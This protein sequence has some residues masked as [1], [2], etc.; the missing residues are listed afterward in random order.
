MLNFN[1]TK[2]LS[3]LMNPDKIL[4]VAMIEVACTGG[5][6]YN[7]Y[8]RGGKVEG[9]ERLREETTGAVFWLFGVKV[10]NK[11][12]DFIGNKIGIKNLD[13]DLGKDELR[14]P[15]LN[16][17]KDGANKTIAFKFAKVAGSA[18]IATFFLGFVLPKI[19]QKITEISRNKEQNS[20]GRHSGDNLELKNNA[21]KTEISNNQS[22]A[23]PFAAGLTYPS[24]D[25]FINSAKQRNI[26]FKGASPVV[27]FLS[28]AAYNLENKTA[29][30]LMS[31]DVGMIA[32][33]VA[34]SRNKIEGFEFL[35]RD[36]TSIYFYL[37]ATP[38][39]VSLLNKMTGNTPIH[40]DSLEVFKNHL[41]NSMGDKKYTLEEF[42]RNTKET[43]A[44]LSDILTKIKFEKDVTSL[45]KFN[46][47]TSGL[48]KEK[49][50]KMSQLQPKMLGESILSKQ[51]VVDIL[52]DGWNTDPEFIK[53]ALD[54]GTYGAASNPKK[55]VT[56]KTVEGIRDSI[57]NFT[58]NLVKYASDKGVKEIDS[59]F[60]QN[61]AKR[62]TNMNFAFRALGMLV[63]GFGIAFLI[64]KI[65]YKL[66]ELRTG[67]KEFPGTKDYSNADNK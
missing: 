53:K 57:D 50:F 32:G 62:T 23:S 5:R 19:N 37:F 18:A 35:F 64:P 61:F 40:P 11:I 56:R 65:Q 41:V 55:F 66:T 16:N 20:A 59:N 13:V 54:A 47:S 33:R 1:T 6:T 51:Q 17:V 24:M 28:T 9:R 60:V 4:P 49:A 42:K 29:W 7:G 67:S 34:N 2:A 43:P 58:Q 10:L 27:D 22:F 30:R 44:D 21:E 36:T 63:S 25:N 45:D 39:V 14:A 38:H 3:T 31:T 12:G 52:S 46:S 15:F 48:Y 26:S 8:K